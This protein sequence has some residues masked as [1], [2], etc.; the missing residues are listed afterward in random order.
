MIFAKAPKL[1]GVKTRLSLPAPESM[2]L[3][4]AFV[5]DVVHSSTG[6][7]EQILWSDD[8]R[9]P[10]FE[11][12]NMP[13]YRQVGEGLS[14]RLLHA[15]E[16]ALTV[17]SKVV[18]IGTD[19]PTLPKQRLSEA[20]R[21][22][23]GNDAVIGPSCDGGYYLLGLKK[24]QPSVFD[25]ML[26]WSGAALFVQTMERFRE[27][28]LSTMV[29]PFW[30]DVDRPIDLRLLDILTAQDVAPKT[31]AVLEMLKRKKLLESSR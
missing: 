22:L 1:G 21:A 18:V 23:D 25:P 19:A 7:W 12:F 29:L 4:E 16:R 8:E 6:A 3:H 17:H 27:A 31:E 30:F 5:E 24:V 13:R 9:H 28:Q 26:D 10:F 15:F 11:R 2:A 20:F 14:A